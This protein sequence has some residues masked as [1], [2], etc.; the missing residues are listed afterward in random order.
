[1]RSR[2]LQLS[3]ILI[4]ACVVGV[5]SGLFGV[6]GGVLLVPLLVLLFAFDQHTAQGTSL[7]ALVPPVGLLAF[8]NYARA[9]EVSWTVGLLIMPGVFI[10][11]LL[12][13]RLAQKLSPRRMR[14]VF[15]VFLLTLG[16]W[17]IVSAWVMKR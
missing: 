14:R 4:V 9:Q 15:A 2:P 3:L 6:G 17:Q 7:I 8:L 16:V 1:V 10:G 5:F 11:G 12:G 13:S